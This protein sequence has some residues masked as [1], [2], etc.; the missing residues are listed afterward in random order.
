MIS[1]SPS[2]PG[3]VAGEPGAGPRGRSTLRNWVPEERGPRWALAGIVVAGA[4][5]RFAT[6][7]LQ[8]FSPDEGFTV[9]MTRMSFGRML[10]TLPITEATPPLHYV[11][12][13]LW[14]RVFGSDEAGMRSLSALAGTA[15]IPVAYSIGA[16]L[17]SRRAATIGAAL[18]A[19]SPILVYYSQ[20]ARSYAL[21]ALL[22][23][24]SLLC[25]ISWVQQR[26]TLHLTGW[27]VASALALLT[28]YF[29]ITVVGPEAAFV[30][31]VARPRRPAWLACAI[32][33]AAEL[34][35][36]PLAYAQRNPSSGWSHKYAQV[37]TSLL[38]RVA[39]VPREMLLGFE[40]PL[41]VPL[42]IVLLALSIAAISWIVRDARAAELRGL[43]ERLPLFATG[44]AAIAFVGPMLP[45][46]LGRS[47]DLVFTRNFLG[48]M[49][50][51]QAVLAA[52]F[53]RRGAGMIAA[54]LFTAIS[55]AMV[56][57]VD[58][59]PI[60]QRPD[61]RGAAMALGPVHGTRLVLVTGE[62]VQTSRL[63]L[64][65]QQP[66]TAKTRFRLDEIDVIAMPLPGTVDP[67]PLR[68]ITPPAPG[69]SEIEHRATNRYTLVRFRAAHTLPVTAA[70]ATGWPVWR[71]ALATSRSTTAYLLERHR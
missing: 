41:G 30:V 8:S 57:A 51:L 52:G 39:K 20:E 40:V 56:L 63:Y 6:L 34:A 25:L 14:A 46:M 60:Y 42:T 68:G 32:P 19:S 59:D 44:L 31:W 67:P 58:L 71:R 28:H 54:A 66:L 10:H 45:A 16:R 9:Q 1:T 33:A 69:F 61:I 49:V 27:A 35:L 24:I 62:P 65:D 22:V 26:R 43:A 2:R 21:Y 15:L 18:T 47:L 7:G 38:V 70:E 48:A 4:V 17:A 64:P 29:A 53:A 12:V 5:L 11:L 23:G 3:T 50:V 55:V 37:G 36:V 13:W